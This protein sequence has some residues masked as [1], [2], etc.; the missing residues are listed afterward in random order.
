MLAH[1]LGHNFGMLHDFD[2]Y[3]GGWTG[4]CNR[5]G[6]M[7]YGSYDYDQWS[8]CSRS[9][10]ENSYY[11]WNWGIC[12]ENLSGENL[13]DTNLLQQNPVY[14]KCFRYQEYLL[15]YFV[16]CVYAIR[17]HRMILIAML[18]HVEL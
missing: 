5:K 14:H 1:E 10:M 13:K 18:P 16:N 17:Q 7:S 8:T 3:N 4:P 2:A 12:L 9:N 11:Q 6:I 15:S